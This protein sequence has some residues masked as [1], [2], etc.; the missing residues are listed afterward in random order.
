MPNYVDNA[1]LYDAL[2]EYKK[3]CR[4]SENYGDDTPSIPEYI[5]E[6]FLMIGKG[7]SSKPNF[8]NYTCLLYTSDAADE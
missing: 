1:K 4:V 2:L 5:A 8:M 3:L 7:L 6:C